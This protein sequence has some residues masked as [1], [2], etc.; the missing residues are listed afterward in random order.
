MGKK[1]KKVVA[2]GCGVEEVQEAPEKTRA[3]KFPLPSY[4]ENGTAWIF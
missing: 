1:L 4:P 3:V 2:S